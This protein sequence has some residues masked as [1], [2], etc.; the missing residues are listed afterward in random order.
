M[1]LFFEYL[2]KYSY[3]CKNKKYIRKGFDINMIFRNNIQIIPKID[4]TNKK[5]VITVGTLHNKLW[6]E[7]ERTVIDVIEHYE[8]C[9][10]Q[11]GSVGLKIVNNGTMTDSTVEVELDTV[12][13]KLL[14]SDNHT[15]MI[16]EYVEL[17][18]EQNHI[19]KYEEEIYA[20]RSEI[21]E[22]TLLM[23]KEELNNKWGTV[24]ILDYVETV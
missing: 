2:N 12:N 18:A 17:I 22:S 14:E 10:V 16:D 21:P 15:Y 6:K 1:V 11:D 8:L 9:N 7:K 19:E 3:F 24:T 13:S 23:S 20:K 5:N 4:E